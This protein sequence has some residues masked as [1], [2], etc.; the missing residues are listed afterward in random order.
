MNERKVEDN[1]RFKTNRKSMLKDKY[2]CMW[3]QITH[4]KTKIAKSNNLIVFESK[5][6]KVPKQDSENRLTL[7]MLFMLEGDHH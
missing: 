3:P 1:N 5:K 7:L 2:I 4:K 6:T